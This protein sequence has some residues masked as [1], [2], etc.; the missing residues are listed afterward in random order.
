MI[1]E[2]VD[3]AEVNPSKWQRLAGKLKGRLRQKYKILAPEIHRRRKS[4]YQWGAVV[5]V[6]LLAI[7]ILG[8]ICMERSDGPEAAPERVRC[9]ANLETIGLACQIYANSHGVFPASFEDMMQENH[10]DAW[11]FI[12]GGTHDVPAPGGTTKQ[13]IGHLADGGHC[14]YIYVGQ[15]LPASSP[16]AANIVVAYESLSNHG[17]AGAHFLYADGSVRWKAPKDAQ[18]LI[19]SL[20][21]TRSA[22]SSQ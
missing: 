8:F 17:G 15:G 10:L 21:T 1:I 16:N 4:I 12:C 11:T 3:D 19:D 6:G 5:G 18:A 2:P 7:V 14:S 9:A 13:Q 22:I 20:S